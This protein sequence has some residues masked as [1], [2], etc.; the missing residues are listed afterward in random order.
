MQPGAPIAGTVLDPVPFDAEAPGRAGETVRAWQVFKVVRVWRGSPAPWTS[1]GADVVASLAAAPVRE[2]EVRRWRARAAEA[3]SADPAAG[4][5][6][7]G[8]AKGL[9]PRREAR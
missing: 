2:S 9:A 5:G 6:G 8:A 1:I 7:D 3:A 4:N